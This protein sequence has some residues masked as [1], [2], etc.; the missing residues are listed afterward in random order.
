MLKNTLDGIDQ[1]F[2]NASWAHLEGYAG[3]YFPQGGALTAYKENK[4]DPYLEL[5]LSHGK[6]P[7]DAAYAYTL[8]PNRTAEETAA[9]AANPDITV[10]SN[11]AAIQAVREKNT[12]ITGMVFWQPG[13][14]HGFT[15]SIPMVVMV[16]ET[17]EGTQIAVSDPSM[18]H[19]SNMTDSLQAADCNNGM[20]IH[21]ETVTLTVNRPLTLVSADS[22]I[23]A[24]TKA[25]STVLEINFGLSGKTLGAKLR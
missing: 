1:T 18:S 15:A 17:A 5:F 2:E 14:F 19:G 23:K 13:T 9:Y 3:Y 7:K 22:G 24:E 25:D 4:S 10:L 8:M 11:T 20:S 6:N 12:N 16:K 21:D